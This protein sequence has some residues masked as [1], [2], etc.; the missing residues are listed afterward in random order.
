[1]SAQYIK[2]IED[3]VFVLTEFT[4]FSGRQNDFMRQNC[5]V[6]QK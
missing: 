6:R 1:M 3:I 4:V 5:T 2:E